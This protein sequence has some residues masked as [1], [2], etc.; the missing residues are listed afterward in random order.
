MYEFFFLLKS[1]VYIYIYIK[2]NKVNDLEVE[3]PSEV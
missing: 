1:L 3:I 2:V